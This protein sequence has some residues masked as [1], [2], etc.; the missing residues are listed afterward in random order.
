MK[1]FKYFLK[2]ILKK[3]TNASINKNCK[4]RL[5]HAIIKLNNIH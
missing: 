2:L 1:Y 4:N 3:K 5:K